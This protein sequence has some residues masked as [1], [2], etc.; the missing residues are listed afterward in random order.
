MPRS[1]VSAAVIKCLDSHFATH[2]VPAGSNMVTEEME[3]CLKEMGIVHHCKTLLWPRAN[4]E[5]ERKNLSLLNAMRVSQAEENDWRRSSTSFYW[6]A[7]RLLKPHPVLPHET[8][9]Q[10]ETNY[11]ATRVYARW[12]ESGGVALQQVRDRDSK[13]Q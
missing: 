12:R 13:K 11:Q 6:P 9:F 2:G 8:V 4:V 1:S 3:K 7:D 5:V 10:D